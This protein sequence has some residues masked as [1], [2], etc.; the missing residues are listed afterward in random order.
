MSVNMSDLNDLLAEGYRKNIDLLRA[1]R[2]T[3]K[4]QIEALRNA[5]IK[6]RTMEPEHSHPDHDFCEECDLLAETRRYGIDQAEGEF[7]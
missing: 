2:N 7:S 6:R 4:M 1:E 5:L 3:M